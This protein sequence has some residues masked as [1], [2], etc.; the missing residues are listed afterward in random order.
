MD[1]I[2]IQLVN[3]LCQGSIYALM[4]IGYASIVGVV[5]LVT[6]A[7]GE[8]MM[9]GAFAAYYTFLGLIDHL[10]VG[11][12]ASFAVSAFMGFLV[13]KICYERFF[14]KPRHISLI[15]TIGFSMLVKNLAQIFFGANTKAMP[16]VIENFFID[17]GPVR[18]NAVQIIIVATVITL[19]A[20]LYFMFNKTTLGIKLRAVSQNRQAAALVGINVKQTTLL[21]NCIGCGIGGV[22]GMLLA[23]YYHSLSPIIGSTF[24][25]KAFASSVVG[26]MTSIPWA[27]G[28]GVLIGVIENLGTAFMPNS[29]RDVFAFLFLFI[30]L[31]IRP[32]GLSKKKGI[33][34]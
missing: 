27:A 13:Y 7:Y 14:D 30:V 9:I 3:G 17:I 23:M 29:Y 31:L 1:Y 33:R 4:A 10:L 32:E 28:G 20:A 15:C 6:F 2:I 5:G 21:G 34:P 26:G 8:V 25:N 11:V 22:A 24:G 12:V 16:E 18:I 19:S